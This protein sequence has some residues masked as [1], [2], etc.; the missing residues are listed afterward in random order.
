MGGRTF[1]TENHP[2][3][4][5]MVHDNDLRLANCGISLSKYYPGLS[6]YHFMLLLT[7]DSIYAVWESRGT[8]TAPSDQPSFGGIFAVPIARRC[9]EQF[10]K[11]AIEVFP[12]ITV[13]QCKN[14][15]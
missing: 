11:P 15:G 7:N 2:F 12:G 5:V 6:S 13:F 4:D 8:I 1:G 14:L 3:P 9:P 10:H